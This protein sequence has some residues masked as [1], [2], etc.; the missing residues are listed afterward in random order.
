MATPEAAVQTPPPI[1]ATIA[2]SQA[3]TPLEAWLDLFFPE[4]RQ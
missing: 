1:E 3:E 4:A 2:S